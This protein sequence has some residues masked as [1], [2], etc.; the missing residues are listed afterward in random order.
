MTKPIE[1]VSERILSCAKEGF[2]EKGYADASLRTIAAKA[3]T[4]TGSIYSRFR[5]KEG[6]FG[7]LVEPAAGGRTLKIF[8]FRLHLPTTDDFAILPNG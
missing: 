5:D 1:G 8:C 3:E 2:L 6:L 4:T 7:A